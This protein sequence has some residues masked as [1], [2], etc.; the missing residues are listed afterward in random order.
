[1][2]IG[3]EYQ[4]VFQ[5]GFDKLPP[6]EQVLKLGSLSLMLLA[7]GLLLAPGA[8]H[9][10]VAHGQDSTDVSDFTGRIAALALLPFALGMGIDVYVTTFVVLEH[11]WPLVFG[12][13]AAVTAI[14]F[15]YGLEWL[16]RLTT[17]TPQEAY[18]MSKPTELA[19]R[20]KQV[21]TE[22]RVVLP[23]ARALL[24]FQFAAVLTDGFAKLPPMSQYVHLISLALIGVSIV[25]LMAPAAFHRIVERGEDT[26]R[27]HAFASAMV[28]AAMVTLALGI[29]GDFYVVLEKVLHNQQLAIMLAGVAVAFFYGLWFGLTAALRTRQSKQVVTQPAR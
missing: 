20:I 27:L 18:D 21:L 12:V 8:Y 26:E 6:Q 29:A 7:V 24:G 19:T 17:E 15:W 22:A 13:A 10:L 9:Q 23:G 16:V 11:A 28:L 4:A 14:F 25:F 3:F 5:P 2:F 1:M